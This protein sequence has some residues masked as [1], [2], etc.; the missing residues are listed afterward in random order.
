MLAFSDP[1]GV[2]SR[3]FEVK[4][5]LRSG[6]C[7]GRGQMADLFEGWKVTSHPDCLLPN[8]HRQ[9]LITS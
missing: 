8:V 5:E 4:P 9:T 1:F 7:H 6:A 3:V 2:G